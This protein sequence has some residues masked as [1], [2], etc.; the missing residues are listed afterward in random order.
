MMDPKT[1]AAALTDRSATPRSPTASYP[2]GERC[3]PLVSAHPA[4]YSQIFEMAADA[5]QNLVY[6]AKEGLIIFDDPTQWFQ[7]V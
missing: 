7:L 4:L 2:V 3:E 5:Q 6:L 1:A